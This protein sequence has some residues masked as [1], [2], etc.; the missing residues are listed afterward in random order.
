MN[1]IPEY[2]NLVNR[3]LLLR[4]AASSIGVA[5]LCGCGK[6]LYVKWVVKKE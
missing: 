5:A 4:G 1:P 6:S 2:H 3:R